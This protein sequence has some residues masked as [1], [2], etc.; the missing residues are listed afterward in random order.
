MED[1][2]QGHIVIGLR[3]MAFRGKSIHLDWVL[4]RKFFTVRVVRK[5]HVWPKE[6]GDVPSLAVLKARM[7]R[8]LD[9]GRCPCSLQGVGNK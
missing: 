1:V 7:D 8:A 5:W 6:A 3:E 4:G 2:S 9:S